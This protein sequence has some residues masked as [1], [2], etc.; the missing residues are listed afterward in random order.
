[1]STSS[2]NKGFASVYF[3]T[4]FTHLPKY[5]AKQNFFENFFHKI[6][7]TSKRQYI[8]AVLI[9]TKT[10]PFILYSIDSFHQT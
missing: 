3:A 8:F 1:M 10:I 7:H 6:L 2:A 9:K 5:E 4:Y